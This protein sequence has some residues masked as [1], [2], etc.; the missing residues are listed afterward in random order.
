MFG[1]PKGSNYELQTDTGV[2][3]VPSSLVLCRVIR[4][5]APKFKRLLPLT[6]ICNWCDNYKSARAEVL[7]FLFYLQV[8]MQKTAYSGTDFIPFSNPKFFCEIRIE[9]VP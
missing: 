8:V 3:A 9:Y 7:E 6:P 2:D 5:F 4:R 1:F